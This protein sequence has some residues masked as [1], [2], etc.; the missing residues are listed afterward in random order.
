VGHESEFL[1]CDCLQPISLGCAPALAQPSFL[2]KDFSIADPVD[3]RL[4]RY[5]DT[6]VFS[7]PP[8]F[9]FGN[10]AERLP[11]IRNDGQ[12]NFDL[13][14]IKEFRPVE[15]LRAE[16]R[17]EL[18]NAFNTPRFGTPNTSVTSSSFGV[19]TTQVNTPRQIQCI[20]LPGSYGGMRSVG[21]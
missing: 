7:Q 8:P 2:R 15:K 9:T 13:S 17:L 5:F 19:I 14:V 3:R 16:F 11:D 18:L 21:G 6:S 1:T 10:L 4:G 12:R 20:C